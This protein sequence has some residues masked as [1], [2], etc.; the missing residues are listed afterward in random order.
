MPIIIDYKHDT[1]ICPICNSRDIERS[2]DPLNTSEDNED[3]KVKSCNKCGFSVSGY[4]WEDICFNW[5]LHFSHNPSYKV[6]L[7]GKSI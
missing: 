4:S 7:H 5:N 2:S 6:I 3:A 1:Q